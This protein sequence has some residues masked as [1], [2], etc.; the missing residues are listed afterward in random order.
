MPEDFAKLIR[1]YKPVFLTGVP[2]MYEALIKNKEDSD[3]LKSVKYCIS[4]GDLLSKDLR[5]RVN[6]YLVSHGSS[7]QIRVG[8]GLTE[9]TAACILTPN[10]YFREGAIGRPFQDTEVKIVK[11]GTTRELKPHRNG[12]ICITGP[13]VMLGYLNEEEETNNTLI[14]HEDGKIWLHTGDLGYVDKNGIIFFVSRLKRMF[15]TSGYNIYPLYME[16]IIEGHPAVDKCVVVGIPHPYKKKVPVACIVLKENY[17]ESSELTMDIKKYCEKSIAKYSM[18]Y[19]YEYIR[20]VPKTII[21]K[22]NY[23]KLEDD[24]TRKYS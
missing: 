21:G 12:E 8:Y 2:T 1:R 7:A 11:P 19:K 15:V 9:S 23:K 24:C 13:T 5:T 10:Y 16:K 17:K 20:N 3:F 18:P 4:G 22:I 6:S 14:K